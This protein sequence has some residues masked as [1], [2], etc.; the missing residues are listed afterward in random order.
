LKLIFSIIFFCLLVNVRCDAQQNQIIP[1]AKEYKIASTDAAPSIDGLDNDACWAN[2]SIASGFTQTIPEPLKPSRFTTQVKMC[3]TNNAVFVLARMQKPKSDIVKQLCERDELSNI[4]ADVFTVFFDT[5]NDQQ[6]GYAFRVSSANVQQDE[7]QSNGGSAD[8]FSDNV[9]RGWD[10]VWLSKVRIDDNGWTVEIEIPFSALRIPKD[11]IQN[12][13][14]QFGVLHRKVNE[15]SFWNQVDVNTNGFY[16]QAGKLIG[17]QNI[18]APLR[19]SL[20]P[21]LSAGYQSVPDENGKRTNQFFPSGGMD[22]KYGINDAFTLDA[23]LV[24]DFSQVVSDNLVRNLS[25]FEQRLSENRPFFTE[26]TELFNKQDLLYTRRLGKRPS[27][28][29]NVENQYGNDSLYTISK[30]PNITNLYNAIKLSGR[31][32]SKL[33]IGVFNAIGAPMSATVF[34]KTTQQEFKV[35]TEPLAN[36][37][38]VVLDQALSGQNFINFTNA[39]TIRNGS[40]RDA[41]VAGVS[42]NLFTKNQKYQTAFTLKQSSVFQNN[43]SILGTY[44]SL[45]IGNAQGKFR[46]NASTEYFSKNF[47]Q[48]DLGLQFDFNHI[49]H[50]ISFNYRNNTPRNKKMQLRNYW[51]NMTAQENIAPFAFKLFEINTGTFFLFK[52]FWDVSIYIN[53]KPFGDYNFYD[54]GRFSKRL[55]YQPYAYVGFEGSSDSR[56]KLFISYSSGYGNNFGNNWNY[57]DGGYGVRYNFSDKLSVRTSINFTLNHAVT[58]NT[59]YETTNGLP[60]V[61]YRHN[62]EYTWDVVAKYNLNPNFSINGRFRHYNSFLIYKKFYTVDDAGQ[63]ENLPLTYANNIDENFNLQNID[64]FVNWIFKPGS[65][66]VVSYKQWL[67]DQYIINEETNNTFARNITRIGEQPKAFLLSARVIWYLDYNKVKSSLAKK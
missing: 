16:V 44:G 65:R 8:A 61:G 47:D 20:F 38:V 17:L 34:D 51:L 54:L 32:S 45:L 12:W 35:S 6:N 46:W 11:A 10:A 40:A 62:N 18:K 55:F 56:K 21:Y 7:R 13:N 64:V 63:W 57:I 37:N 2:A 28:F 58:G 67:N 41:N 42:G 14:L 66:I 22:V 60:L 24:P 59:F 26:G 52:N 43:E 48:T 25:V 9:D 30:N 19:L 4:N 3:Y 1:P 49:S 5:Y 33:G 39:N 23:T 29:Y 27:G 31:T 36:Y 15:T 53:S 50:N